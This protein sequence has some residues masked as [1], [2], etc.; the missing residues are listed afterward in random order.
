MIS[1][2]RVNKGDFPIFTVVGILEFFLS[3][4]P[5]KCLINTQSRAAS[6]DSNGHTLGSIMKFKIETN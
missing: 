3:L 1:D 4:A 6:N 2:N 5:I